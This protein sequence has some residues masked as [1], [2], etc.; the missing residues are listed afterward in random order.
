M[1]KTGGKDIEMAEVGDNFD[2]EVYD[3]YAEQ[4]RQHED[5]QVHFLLK[6]IETDFSFM[7]YYLLF[8]RISLTTWQILIEWT[9]PKHYAERQTRRPGKGRKK[10][11]QNRGRSS[12]T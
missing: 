8:C 11:L 12:A 4:D 2:E 7:C 6:T 3:E 1:G 5:A 9:I 10:P